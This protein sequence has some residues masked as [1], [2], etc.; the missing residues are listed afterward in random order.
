M[1]NVIMACLGG[2]LAGVL[3]GGCASDPR[4]VVVGQPMVVPST[5][6][7]CALAQKEIASAR[8]PAR[9]VVITDA[10]A[11]ARLTPSIQPLETAQFVQYADAQRTKARMISCKL[12]SADKIRAAYGAT[13]AGE[14]TTCAR[15]NRRTLDAVMASMSDRQ[16]KKMPFTGS[17]PILLDPDEV[18][19]NEAQW[20]EAFTMVQTDAG[21]TLRI[22]AKS[23]RGEGALRVSNKPATGGRQYCHLIAP[24]YL[25]RIL[26]GEVKLPAGEFPD[27][28]RTVSR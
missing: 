8:V 4:P 10:Q 9:N 12:H 2:L 7:Y 27:A 1:K 3:V 22:R 15:L 6:D 20:L 17:V 28:G 23:L 11:F 21:G 13:A 26:L 5:S 16:K 19:A 25:K 18:A 24:D 14:S